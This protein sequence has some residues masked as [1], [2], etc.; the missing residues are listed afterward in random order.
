MKG[1]VNFCRVSCDAVKELPIHT[2]VVQHPQSRA[3]CKPSQV[4]ASADK[5]RYICLPSLRVSVEV[6]SQPHPLCRPETPHGRCRVNLYTHNRLGKVCKPPSLPLPPFLW[7]VRNWRAFDLLANRGLSSAAWVT[8]GRGRQL[9]SL[10][11]YNGSEPTWSGTNSLA[12]YESISTFIWKSHSYIEVYCTV[13]AKNKLHIP[14]IHRTMDFSWYY[15]PL[16]GR[17]L[18]TA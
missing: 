18:A 3:Q 12:N 10:W 7:S 11:L 13:K 9:V 5:H 6:G 1:R 2:E 16:Y 4:S 14:E 15:Y 8:T 17:L